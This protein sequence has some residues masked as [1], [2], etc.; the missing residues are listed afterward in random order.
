MKQLILRDITNLSLF[1]HTC[2]K[3]T[4]PSTH[5]QG[6]IYALIENDSTGFSL[7]SDGVYVLRNASM[8]RCLDVCLVTGFEAL[9]L[10]K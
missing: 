5:K 4:G 7:L 3:D 6:I 2:T 1:P 10:T 9:N 8:Y